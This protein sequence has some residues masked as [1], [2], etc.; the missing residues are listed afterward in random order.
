MWLCTSTVWVFLLTLPSACSTLSWPPAQTPGPSPSLSS[1]NNWGPQSS[2]LHPP[3]SLSSPPWGLPVLIHSWD[4]RTT[5]S[6][7]LPVGAFRSEYL[8]CQNRVRGKEEVK[9]KA[10]LNSIIFTTGGHALS[11]RGRDPIGRNSPGNS[12]LITTAGDPMSGGGSLLHETKTPQVV[13]PTLP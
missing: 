2:V 4:L 5:S 10:G 13:V 6:P 9:G 7:Q 3:R 1:L 8:S 11:Q 12:V